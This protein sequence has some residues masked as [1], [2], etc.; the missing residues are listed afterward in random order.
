MKI[1][2]TFISISVAI[3]SSM[4]ALGNESEQAYAFDIYVK[5]I[6]IHN[7]VDST[8]ATID[9]CI[10]NQANTS[11]LNQDLENELNKEFITFI[12]ELDGFIRQ[13]HDRF[14]TLVGGKDEKLTSEEFLFSMKETGKRAAKKYH[15][16]KT[17]EEL[18]RTCAANIRNSKKE[19]S[20]YYVE[21]QSIRPELIQYYGG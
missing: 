7:K 16:K 14:K 12:T 13:Q 17:K 4:Q 5:T 21:F 20:G 18:Y 1:I 9:Y 11:S 10:E 2:N 6:H 3:F 15:S 8:F 19:M